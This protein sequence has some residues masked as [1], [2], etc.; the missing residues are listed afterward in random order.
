MNTQKF[1]FLQVCISLIFMMT[2]VFQPAS[3]ASAAAGGNVLKAGETLA[4]GKYIISPDGQYKFV[5]QSDSNLVVYYKT[6]A[7]WASKTVG[8]GGIKL[9]M[10]SDGNLV[11][12]TAKNV[13]VWASNTAGK[14][15]SYLAMQNDGNLVIY[16]TSGSATWATGIKAIYYLPYE[17]GKSFYVVRTDHSSTGTGYAIDFGM[18]V[19]TPVLAARS[20]YIKKI[21]ETQTNSGCVSTY[22]NNMVVIE[23]RT[24]GELSYYLH[25]STNSVPDNL[26]EGSY[27]A[28]GTLIGKSGK[29]G[30]VCPLNGGDGA[31]LHFHVTNK[32]GTRIVPFFA[33]VSGGTVVAYKTYT[34]GN[35]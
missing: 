7:V 15:T 18:P 22:V 25:L 9:V 10:Q 4:S 2:L 29:I 30:F 32:S 8:K 23:D 21:V 19:G 16:T 14:G 1:K 5:L 24:T 20:G 12:Y 34:S 17:S 33:D 28:R 26:A 13:A 11:L 6:I 27:V 3:F 35:K 31:H